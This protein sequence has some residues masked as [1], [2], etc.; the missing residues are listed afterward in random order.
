A[1]LGA[2]Y[3]AVGD[4]RRTLPSSFEVAPLATKGDAV[5]HLDA[6]L[7]EVYGDVALQ[8]LRAATFSATRDGAGGQARRDGE[9]RLV[10]TSRGSEPTAHGSLRFGGDLNLVGGQ[11]YTTSMTAFDIAG[12][13]SG[14][15]LRVQSPQ[16]GDS[17]SQAPLSAAGQLRL[18]AGQI[19][20]DAPLRQPFGRI[21]LVADAIELMARAELSVSGQGLM[22]PVGTTVNGRRWQYRPSGLYRADG[23][24]KPVDATANPDI[25]VLDALPLSAG[26][27]LDATRLDV[28]PRA[29][30]AA[31]AGG[32][33]QAWEFVAGVGG[34][35]D[36]LARSGLYAVL[37]THSYAF[38]PHDPE[39]MAGGAA[40]TLKPGATLTITM[41]G[42]AL[43]P[44]RY[45]LLPA[46]YALLPG[47]VVVSLADAGRGVLAG[48]V[49]HDDGS[50]TVSGY[51]GAEGGQ[52]T[53]GTRIR[54]EP[55]AVIDARSRLDRTSI[56]TFL[57]SRAERLDQS[58]PRLPSDGGRIAIVGR[59]A[60]DLDLRLDLHGLR[61]A[62]A[63]D[64]AG[65]AGELDLAIRDGAMAIVDTV[66]APPA[67]VSGDDW[68]RLSVR[69]LSDSGAGSILLGGL[70][71]G[72]DGQLL[73][74]LNGTVRLTATQVALQAEEVTLLARQ[75]VQLDSGSL[76]QATAGTAQGLPR[77]AW[78]LEGGAAH[79][80]VSSSRAAQWSQTGTTSDRGVLVAQAGA[81]VSAPVVR[82]G[83]SRELSLDPG[84]ALQAEDLALAG[85][86]LH[87]G[88]PQ[89]GPATDGTLSGAVLLATRAATHLR[90]SAATDITFH[91]AHDYAL[92]E[93]N[94]DAALI[95]GVGTPDQLVR[96]EADRVGLVNLGTAAPD[97]QAMGGSRLQVLARATPGGTTAPMLVLGD[98]GTAGTGPQRLAFAA[99]ELA[100]D[101]DLR[102][103]G[104]GVLQ[105]QGDLTLAA[106]R[107]TAATGAEYSVDAA[108][109]ALVLATRAASHQ[110]SDGAIGLGAALS[111]SGRSVTQGGQVQAAGGELRFAARGEAGSTGVRFTSDSTTQVAGAVLP[112][113]VDQ[114][115]H[116]AGGRIVATTQAGD[117]R[118]DGLLDASAR[119]GA[120][121]GSI[122]IE[123]ADTA[124]PALPGSIVLTA[125]ARVLAGAEAGGRGGQLAL[126]AASLR[127]ADPGGPAVDAWAQRAQAGGIDG[128]VEIRIRQGDLVL[129]AATLRAAR[130]QL[131][132]DA[133]A[134]RIG[135][136]LVAESAAGGQVR[137][138]AAGDLRLDGQILAASS[139]SGA[140]GGDVLLSSTGGV[141]R[142]GAAASIDAGGD[143]GRDG[144]VVLR[145]MRDD[146]ARTVAVAADGGFDG[147]GRVRAGEVVVE[148]VRVY[149]G[150][151]SL[152]SG[153]SRDAQLG[154]ASIAADNAAFMEGAV[155][156][157]AAAGLATHPSA[158]LRPGVE[159][160]SSGDFRVVN[161]WNLWTADRPGGQPGLLT[162]RAAGHL[163]LSGSIS[164]G[165]ASA[166]RPN[167][168]SLVTPSEIKEG[169]A[170][171]YRLVAGADLAA[172]NPLAHRTGAEADIDLAAD[173]MLR[174][175]AGSIDLVAARDLRMRSSNSGT[176]AG[177]VYV[178]GQPS[179]VNGGLALTD[180]AWSAQFTSHGGAI[181]AFAGRDILGA[182]T[183][184]LTGA[185][186]YHTGV[187]DQTAV[188]W[189]SAVDAFRHGF[190][191]F[192][193][194]AVQLRA[195]RDILN[196]GAVAPTSA[197]AEAPPDA[198]GQ[199]TPALR[200]ENGGD[201][202]VTAGRD[203]LG[204]S[205]LLGRGEGRIA[206]GGRIGSAPSFNPARMPD[207]APVLAVM[208]G[209]WRLDAG[210][211]LAWSALYNPT[212]LASANRSFSGRQRI[213][214]SDGAVFFTYA[215]TSGLR[216]SSQAGDVHWAAE[217]AAGQLTMSAW[218]STLAA[219]GPTPERIDWSP[220]YQDPMSWAPPNIHLQALGGNVAVT[221]PTG[222]AG[223][224][225]APAARGQLAVHAAGDLTLTA[226]STA[227]LAM[228]DRSPS[229]LPSTVRPVLALRGDVDNF[230][231]NT[232]DAPTQASQVVHDGIHA[233]D[234]Q[235][236]RLHAGGDIL[237]AQAATG[238]RVVL[239]SPKAAQ[240]TAGGDIRD[241]A[242]VGQHVAG[243][244]DTLLRADGSI[245]QGVGA[246]GHRIVQGGGGT[247]ELR[248]GRQ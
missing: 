48:A 131:S 138:H 112:S 23:T 12:L 26:I 70:R 222:S 29:L 202:E 234:A 66:A 148:A 93:L 77:P 155:G 36:V 84:M 227:A 46:R 109:G 8:G 121:A 6:S 102:F 32:S 117:V 144:R 100:A 139:R 132:A 49:R 126:D 115:V 173:K 30:L 193:G 230:D 224:T 81:Q 122:R 74:A 69:T 177:V 161:D 118:V 99:A 42:S 160:Q 167:G 187:E 164:D 53:E 152:A 172:A 158:T 128:A 201:I 141:L 185:W 165:F 186:L 72:A 200:L 174:T 64:P 207:T 78:Q 133:G 180:S 47:A 60:V 22:V 228:S 162:I 236:L 214:D 212:M 157:L 182:P 125:G 114:V 5:L 232:F 221:L 11:V 13:D 76:L 231:S 91:G 79:A 103:D 184:Q 154:Q 73:Q 175:T 176:A 183:P 27:S 247:L 31:Q 80:S 245:V 107:I 111:F 210:R 20:I 25:Q 137:V 75:Q 219:N 51:L 181:T 205:F 82:L 16:A 156:V 86:Q 199:T 38:A 237:L 57:D 94:L 35:T 168:N 56:G 246:V 188:A 135:G 192:G 2:T 203:L 194:G 65:R 116:G 127:M 151:S 229:A 130:L 54:V 110:A 206:A 97:P 149:R 15:V 43:A 95:R 136:V 145:A 58:A 88:L 90:L 41:A 244:D 134:V 37:P 170:W 225:L 213:S 44:G 169:P 50:A 45:T 33:L 240:V 18:A 98:A 68:S 150:F 28:A 235:P 143:D 24:A 89:A 195:G 40:A 208:D 14:S 123:A 166:A 61:Q 101:G 39:V 215:P 178:A 104:R 71:T 146:D 197:Q 238:A 17:S 10:G 209:T 159:I 34:S 105:A 92:R 179:Q 223:L 243:N 191:S 217:T 241:L 124:T 142:L 119:G 204:G 153:F 19:V 59:E 63:A 233:G 83:G 211:D 67:E 198:L 113:G 108:S 239:V 248:A 87:V 147:A 220:K 7:V 218:W 196:L 163:T 106:A 190:G 226:S 140:N 9:V 129:D 55:T 1:R 4:R 3:I 120:D 52:A 171:S 62:T 85:R 21:D 189:W 96:L 242:W 216:A